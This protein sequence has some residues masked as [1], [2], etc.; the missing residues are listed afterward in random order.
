MGTTVTGVEAALA[1]AAGEV[2]PPDRSTRIALALADRR[3]L[4]TEVL[5]LRA[6]AREALG[7]S[8]G[9]PR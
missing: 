8:H 7:D 2:F 4:A 9:P 3:T 1:R 5:R 6:L